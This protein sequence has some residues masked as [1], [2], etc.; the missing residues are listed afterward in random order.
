MRGLSLIGL[1]AG[2]GIV[3]M[4]VFNQLKPSSQTGETLPTKAID[5]AEEAAE[6]VEQNTGTADALQKVEQIEQAVEES[7]EE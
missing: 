1:L 5:R 2:L 4:L 7:T 6:T 3:G